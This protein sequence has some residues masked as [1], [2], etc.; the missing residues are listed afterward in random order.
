MEPQIFK[1]DAF[2]GVNNFDFIYKILKLVMFGIIFIL[3]IKKSNNKISKL[4]IITVTLQTLF[5]IST[6]LNNGDVFRFVGPALTT[7]IMVMLW[8]ILLLDNNYISVLKKV[9]IYLRICFILNAISIF[10]IDYTNFSNITKVYFLGIDNRFVFTFIPWIFFEGIVSIHEDGYLNYKWFI[11]FALCELTLLYKFSVAAM[12]GLLLFM[13][14]FIKNI[15][16][17]SYH[18]FAVNIFL[19]IL[20]IFFKIQNLFGPILHVLRKDTTLSG[21]VYLWDGVINLLKTKPLLGIGMQ[22]VAYDKLFFYQSTIPYYLEHCKVIH[23]HNTLMTFSYRGGIL[24]L[25]LYLIIIFLCMY[26]I[27]KSNNNS[28]LLSLTI[29]TFI[30]IFVLSLFDTIDF[31]CIFL[32]ICFTIN[33]DKFKLINKKSYL[34]NRN[35]TIKTFLNK[36]FLRCYRVFFL[37]LFRVF[38]INKKKIIVSSYNGKAYGDSG[39]YIIDSLLSKNKNYDIFWTVENIKLS[40]SLPDGVKAVKRDSIK[41]FYHLCTSKIWIDNRRPIIEL[42][43]RKKQYYIQTW[44]GGIALKKI[45]GDAEDKLN[46]RYIKAAKKDSKVINLM[47][48]NSK[49][50]TDMYRRAFWYDG[51]IIECGLPRNDILFDLKSHNNIIKK[52][53]KKNNILSKYKLV[54]YAPTFR[55]DENLDVYSFDYNLLLD[56]LDKK[57]GGKHILG[58]RLHPNIASKSSVIRFNDR[59]INLS[60]YEDMHELMIASNILITDYSS[61][62]F[63]FAYTNKPI[64]LFAKDVENYYDERGF[65]F[66]YYSLPFSVSKDDNELVNNIL[67]FNKI[68][69]LKSL[70]QFFKKIGLKESGNASNEISDI[71]IKVIDKD[72]K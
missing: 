11:I 49:F 51:K 25:I 37:S 52:V 18:I 40:S 35:R 26:K 61:S 34:K 23:A 2:V 15:N 45:E 70:N 67:K 27:K 13:F 7:I 39:K 43:K 60:D 30:V 5:F 59:L 53:F 41:H 66:D 42:N 71:I 9:N 48:S 54:L 24:A 62:M 36:L 29:S 28:N 58:L 3:Y 64:F 16:K 31:P 8:E 32:I 33:I 19:N 63:E 10:L 38:P 46:K 47:V 4:F 55:S 72:E 57:F 65:Y 50:C 68:S 1:A 17:Y 12:L 20:L 69:Y 21:R 22:S 6:I 14:S 44:H 56:T